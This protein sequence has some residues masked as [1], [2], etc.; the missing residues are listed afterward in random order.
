V[1][2]KAK[3]KEAKDIA[4]RIAEARSQHAATQKKIDELTK[5]LNVI[6]SQISGVDWTNE[7]KAISAVADL[8]RRRDALPHY[9]RH[10]RREAVQQE[11]EALHLELE[12]AESKRPELHR[13]VEEAERAFNDARERLNTARSRFHE[14]VYGQL[15]DIRRA[16]S[17]AEKMLWTVSNEKGPEAS[18]PLVRSTWQ[19]NMQQPGSEAENLR[20][21]G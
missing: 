17:S 8:E 7:T 2:T 18:G 20:A 10:L 11:L 19:Q 5:E 16:I 1:P 3:T 21:I 14:L 15:S 13:Q 6:P 4:E 12:Q 9:I